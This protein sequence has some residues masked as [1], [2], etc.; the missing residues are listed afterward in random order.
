MTFDSKTPSAGARA[1]ARGFAVRAL[2]FHSS[3]MWQWAQVEQA[4]S[5][6]HQFDM[7]ALVFH[8]NDIVEHLVFPEAFFPDELMW[9]RWPVRLHSIYQNRHYIN[10]VAREAK[11]LGIR[12]YLQIKEIWFAD[13]LLEIVP[14]LRG[15]D[16]SVCPSDPFWWKF[17]DIKMCEL[18]QAVPDL[19][20]VIV[21]PGTRESKVSISANSCRC[22]RCAALSPADWYADLLGAM[23]RPLAAAGKTLAVRDFSYSADQ[24]SHM[25]DAAR[26]CSPDIVISLKNT[27]HDYYPTFPDNPRIGHTAGLRQWIEYDTWGQFFGLGFFPLSVVEDMQRRMRHALASGAEG[28]SLRTDWEVIT[29]AGSFNSPNILNVIG[30]AMLAQDVERDLDGI[31]AAWARHGLYSPMRSASEM[32]PPQVP[33]HPQ[34]PVWLRDYMR[35]SW[36]VMEKAAYVRGHLFHEDDQY[37]ESLAKAF[38]MLVHIHGRDDWEPGASRLLEPTDEN[39]EII[40]AEKEQALAEVRRLG[41]LLRPRELGLPPAVAAELE[42]M[43]GLYEHYVQGY[44][45]CARAVF[46]ADRARRSGEAAW[47]EAAGAAVPPLREFARQIDAVLA[48]THYPHYAYWLLDVSRVRALALDIEAQLA[49]LAAPTEEVTA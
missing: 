11:A 7:N 44:M 40:F 5:F 39:L 46:S 19:A 29:D 27:P 14:G 22:E 3:R 45:L 10:K 47:I 37:P 12:L 48:G 15:A 36:Q 24:Q 4:L 21:S 20:G 49:R 18:V 33:A 42:T 1:G 9:K 25:L 23:E 26:R 8:Q 31:Y 43:L 34:A 2:E 38:D 41:A 16:G 13:A 28:I 30:G 6:M 32:A 35:A 17:L